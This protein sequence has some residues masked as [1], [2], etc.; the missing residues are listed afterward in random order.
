MAPRFFEIPGT[1]NPVTQRHIREYL[2]SLQHHR[3]NHV[4]RK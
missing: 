3:G 2:N 4:S 1:T